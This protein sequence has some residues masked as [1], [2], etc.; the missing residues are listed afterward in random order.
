MTIADSK[1]DK[2]TTGDSL[3]KALWVWDNQA[4]LTLP[5]VLAAWLGILVCVCLCSAFFLSNH[6]PARWVLGGFVASHLIVFGL[7]AAQLFTMRR[8]VVS[9]LHIICWAPGLVASIV[10][11]EAR[12]ADRLYATWSYSVI[13]VLA[14]SFLFDLRDAGTYSYFLISGKLRKLPKPD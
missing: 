13:A 2:A 3:P 7:A 8:G 6:A 10:D 12:S 5:P 4:R 11:A 9:M 1:A 14:I